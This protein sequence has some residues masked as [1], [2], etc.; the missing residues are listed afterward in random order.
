[1]F[2]INV[3]IGELRFMLLFDYE[4]CLFYI[5]VIYVCDND[6]MGNVKFVMFI[7][8]VIVLD[9]NDNMFKFFEFFYEVDVDEDVVVGF[10]VFMFFVVD[11]DDGLNGLVLY[12]IIFSNYSSEFWSLNLFIGEFII[13]GKKKG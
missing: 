10:I 6:D 9:L 3:F 5:L 1:M 2:I 7:V 12:L 8:Y 11:F 13:N 4:E